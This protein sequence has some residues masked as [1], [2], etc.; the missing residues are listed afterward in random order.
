[1]G[2][3][4]APVSSVRVVTEAPLTRPGGW[5]VL[6]GR[7]RVHCPQKSTL[8]G[9]IRGNRLPMVPP[10]GSEATASS[11]LSDYESSDLDDQHRYE[12]RGTYTDRWMNTPS[13]SSKN[14]GPSLMNQDPRP[15]NHFTCKSRRP[16]PF[17]RCTD[18]ASRWN[19]KSHHHP[20]LCD[21]RHAPLQGLGN[22]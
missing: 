11:L 13:L 20:P 14:Q 21:L 10:T 9:E 18:R 17:P 16:S 1:M 2:T 12:L 6:T 19:A 15:K 22:L 5:S 3:N 7:K 4:D 8:H